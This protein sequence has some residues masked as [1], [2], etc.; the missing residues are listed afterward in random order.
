MTVAL[1]NNKSESKE[2]ATISCQTE[3]CDIS[4]QLYS[5]D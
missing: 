5:E 3:I 2:Y 1:D 4:K